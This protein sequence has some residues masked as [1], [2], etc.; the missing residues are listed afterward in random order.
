MNAELVA[1]RGPLSWMLECE[2]CQRA[3]VLPIRGPRRGEPCPECGGDVITLGA[4][5][6]TRD[7]GGAIV[8]MDPVSMLSREVAEATLGD[9]RAAGFARGPAIKRKKRSGKSPTRKV[10][11]VQRGRR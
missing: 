3:F 11:P 4:G 10:V 7:T 9:L 1:E 8:A 2:R 6:P 5:Y